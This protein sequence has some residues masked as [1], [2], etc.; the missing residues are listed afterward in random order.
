MF[1]A[2]EPPYPQKIIKQEFVCLNLFQRVCQFT[3]ISKSLSVYTNSKEFVNL[4]LFK[5]FS[6]YTNSKEFVNLH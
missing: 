5:E 3:L 4:H 6:V 1:S 2:F